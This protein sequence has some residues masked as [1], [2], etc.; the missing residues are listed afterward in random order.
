MSTATATQTKTEASSSSAPSLLDQAIAATKQTESSQAQN[1]LKVLT[2]NAL[3]GTVKWDRSITVTLK[4]TI[5]AIDQT[6]SKQLAK[7]CIMK[8]LIV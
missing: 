6:I 4:N 8:N 7:S 2:E 5:A 1:L 3:N